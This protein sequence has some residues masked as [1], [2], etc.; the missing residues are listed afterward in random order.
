[1]SDLINTEGDEMFPTF[2]NGK[3]YFS[4]NGHKGYGGLDLFVI[5]YNDGDWSHLQNLGATINSEKDDFGMVFN[6]NKT[7][8]F[9]SNRANG[10]GKDDIYF[11]KQIETLTVEYQEIAG[12]FKYKNID[13]E[14]PAGIEVVLLDDEGEIVFKTITDANGSFTFKRIPGEGSYTIKLIGEDGE[15]VILTLF[16]DDGDAMLVA[17]AEGEFVYRKLGAENVGTLAFLT[18]DDIDLAT[19]TATFRGQ[20]IYENIIGE[21]PDDMEVYLLDDEGVIVFKTKTDAFGNFEFRSIPADKNFIV[22]IIENGDNLSLLIYNS[23]N[24]VLSQ[25]SKNSAGEFVYR[26]LSGAYGNNIAMLIDENGEL[27]FPELTMRIVGEFVYRSIAGEDVDGMKFEVL[28]V[29]MNVIATGITDE[30]GKFRLINIPY[31]DEILFKIPEGSPWLKEDLGLNILSKSHDV[32]VAL[33]KDGMGIFKYRFI[34]HADTYLDTIA[35]ADT[36]DIAAPPISDIVDLKN[37]HY[38]KGEANI[39]GEGLDNL[40]FVAD[41]MN[42]DQRLRIHVGGHTS[43]TSS[44]EFNIKLSKKRMQRVKK[45]L[46]DHGVSSDRIIG[47]YYGEAKLISQCENPEDCTEEENRQNRRTELQLFY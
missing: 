30:N 29:E 32:I 13:G 10:V 26:K 40:K 43:T 11:F 18:E 39:L 47:K 22:K 44:A 37:I 8:F 19:N 28:D 23:D 17:N 24:N 45:Y 38:D 12:R 15:E 3:L 2:F 5:D 35:V 33:E 1:M 41:L 16:G 25:L 36:F 34:G 20:F 31:E 7:G 21:Y 42:K 9:S 46:M 4:S 6:K 27:Q 14:V